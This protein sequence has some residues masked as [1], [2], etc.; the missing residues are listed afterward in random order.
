M[1]ELTHFPRFL[2]NAA[3]TL[4]TLSL[5]WE[6]VSDLDALRP[7]TTKDPLRQNGP[8]NVKLQ[9]ENASDYDDGGLVKSALTEHVDVH[10]VLQR[11][12]TEGSAILLYFCGSPDPFSGRL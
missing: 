3:P 9:W 5:R 10:R 11:G 4:R 7:G 6:K 2:L 1:H 8:M 12:G